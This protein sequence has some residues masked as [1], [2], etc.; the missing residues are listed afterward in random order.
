MTMEFSDETL[1]A[2]L[3]GELSED[4]RA[5]VLAAMAE[6]QALS[7]RTCRL[8]SVKERVQL[9]FREPPAPPKRRC[10]KRPAAWMAVAATVLLFLT[11]AVAGWYLHPMVETQRFVLLDE[12]GR[13]SA[14]ATA[15]SDAM[16]IVFHLTSP[17]MTTAG[18]LLDEVET[19]LGAYQQ[20]D[21]P[22]R[23]EVV[24]QGDGLALLRE[25]LSRYKG[26]IEALADQYGNLTFVACANTVHRAE[27][28]EGT[29]VVLLPNAELTESGVAHVVERQ[30]E[31][32]AYIR[33]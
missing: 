30:K 12:S 29:E 13:G 33:I 2:F 18:D 1:N 3:D 6:D 15:D 20:K 10:P 7:E 22:L 8:R 24:A 31:G 19:M 28:K 4:Q 25:R 26:R 14:P 16:R 5:E 9:A 17:D 11:G 23:V 21:R 27:V 32:W